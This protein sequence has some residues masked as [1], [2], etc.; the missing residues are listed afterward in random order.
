M[1]AYTLA[2]THG[3]VMTHIHSRFGSAYPIASYFMVGT[4]GFVVCCAYWA[5]TGWVLDKA[6]PDDPPIAKFDSFGTLIPILPANQSVPIPM[7]Q[8]PNDMTLTV[9][10]IGIC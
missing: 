7:D 10:F 2:K 9:S 4:L 6:E 3:E 5:V 8:A 1:F